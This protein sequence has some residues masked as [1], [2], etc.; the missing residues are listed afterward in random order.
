MSVNFSRP[1]YEMRFHAKGA[2]AMRQ[3]KR[4]HR[5]AMPTPARTG[6]EAVET[7]GFGG[8]GIENLTKML[9]K[10]TV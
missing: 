8:G 1:L 10:Y 6:V 9:Q 7:E 5:Y 4:I 2:R 3:I